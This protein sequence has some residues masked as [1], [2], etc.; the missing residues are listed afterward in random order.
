M[1]VGSQWLKRIPI[2]YG[3]EI[4][5]TNALRKKLEADRTKGCMA[6]AITRLKEIAKE[7]S[8]IDLMQ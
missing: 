7:R 2:Q 5:L 4:A 6:A 3:T 8:N 1:A